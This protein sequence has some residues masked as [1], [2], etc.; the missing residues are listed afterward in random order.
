MRVNLKELLNSEKTQVTAETEKPQESK[1]VRKRVHSL[2]EIRGLALEL[3]EVEVGRI[4]VIRHGGKVYK[5]SSKSLL[6]TAKKAKQ[7]GVQVVRL[8]K[9]NRKWEFRA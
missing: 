2:K 8:V 4:V 5:S 9:V 1:V 6:E 3:S 7:E